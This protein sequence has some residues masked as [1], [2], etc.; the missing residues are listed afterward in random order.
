MIASASEG[1][2]DKLIDDEDANPE[3]GKKDD[4]ENEKIEAVIRANIV[5]QLIKLLGHS[6]SGPSVHQAPFGCAPTCPVP[7]CERKLDSARGPVY[8][9]R[10][11]LHGAFLGAPNTCSK[12]FES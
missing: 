10:V 2:L 3:D 6:S 12:P 1:A 8:A 11:F 5:P 9:G 7:L 4:G